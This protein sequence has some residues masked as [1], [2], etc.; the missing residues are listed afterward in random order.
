MLGDGVVFVKPGDPQA[1]A[2][3]IE[4]LTSDPDYLAQKQRDAR[5]AAERFTSDEIT[6][7]LAQWII[8]SKQSRKQH[9]GV[10]NKLKKVLNSPI[11]RWFFLAIVLAGLLWVIVKNWASLTEAFTALP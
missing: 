9:Q 7:D 2:T 10:M 5:T 8:D 3:A 11:L 1:L 4:A 6:R